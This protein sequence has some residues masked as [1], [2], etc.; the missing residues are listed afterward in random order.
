MPQE[1]TP[2]AISRQAAAIRER[3]AAIKKQLDG[4]APDIWNR[5][6]AT[7]G[8]HDTARRLREAGKFLSGE[9]DKTYAGP[10]GPHSTLQAY[11]EYYAADSLRDAVHYLVWAERDA[12][13]RAEE[14]ARSLDPFRQPCE[15]PRE[16]LPAPGAAPEAGTVTSTPAAARTRDGG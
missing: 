10:W 15:D 7:D 13:L 8:Y 16:W 2:E 11:R 3:L 1:N 6:G 4:Y 5:R 9:H 14:A 12:G